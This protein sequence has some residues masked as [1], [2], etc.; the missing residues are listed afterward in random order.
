VLIQGPTGAEKF[1]SFDNCIENIA[2]PVPEKITGKPGSF[3]FSA[4][5]PRLFKAGNLES[6][7]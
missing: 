5:N 6:L 1:R 4:E 7:P 3:W 2:K